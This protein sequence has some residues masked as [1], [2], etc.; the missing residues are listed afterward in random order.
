MIPSFSA[1]WMTISTSSPSP[2]SGRAPERF[3]VT[4]IR[5]ATVRARLRAA[6]AWLVD[7]YPLVA[8]HKVTTDP[9]GSVVVS[10][11]VPAGRSP[12]GG[13]YPRAATPEPW[14]SQLERQPR[15][16]HGQPRVL[17]SQL[18]P[19]RTCCCPPN[20]PRVRVSAQTSR[21]ATRAVMRPPFLGLPTT[22]TSLAQREDAATNRRPSGEPGAPLSTSRAGLPRVRD[23]HRE[24][25]WPSSMVMSGDHADLQAQAREILKVVRRQARRSFFLEVTGTPKA[26]KTT[27][28]SMISSFFKTCGWSV[29]VLPEQAAKCPLKMKGH[30]FFNTWTT[31][32]ML[33]DFLDLLDRDHD[34][35]ILDRGFFD[36]LVWLELQHGQGQVSPEEYRIFREF[37]LLDRW[38]LTDATAILRVSPATAMVREQ[39]DHLVPRIGTLMHPDALKE[40]NSALDKSMGIWKAGT[41]SRTS[42]LEVDCELP[43]Q[44]ETVAQF[45][46]HLLPR[47]S[48][49]ADPLIAA[50]PRVAAAELFRDGTKAIVWG[51]QVWQWILDHIQVHK[52]SLLE[53]NGDFV[54]L[55]ACGATVSRGGVFVFNR[56]GSRPIRYGSRTILHRCHVTCD[57][58]RSLTLEDVRHALVTRLQELL[59]T[60]TSMTPMPIGLVWDADSKVETNHMGIAFS[61]SLEAHVA[62]FL[63]EKEFRTNGRGHPMTSR[64][65]LPA[66]LRAVHDLD[67]EPWSKAVLEAFWL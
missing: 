53:D 60:R 27:S 40:F 57:P 20:M 47:I 64:F 55:V 4:R 58:G 65:A 41:S 15:G 5:Q 31:C 32:E 9:D 26:G 25:R 46:R 18:A 6:V 52:R 45:I 30:F 51:Q 28:I 16:R 43:D 24:R 11:H 17:A 35:V 13:S 29:H 63:M 48:E 37:V 12:S 10:T 23:L 22:S 3:K 59:H 50:V 66:D 49:W 62:D 33:S 36:A 7:E 38:Q 67:L 39:D 14:S 54:Q 42:I 34:L 61:I 21:V 2:T 8:G 56:Q 19:C 44:K 1:W